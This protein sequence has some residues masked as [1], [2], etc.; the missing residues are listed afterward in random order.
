M[1]G[2]TRNVG[3]KVV[4]DGEKEYKQALSE[5]SAG[6]KTLA[7]EMRKLQAEYKGNTES[8]EYLT[9]AGELLERKLLQQ[10]DKVAKLREA[11]S[12]AAKEYGE[13]SER[14]QYYIQQLNNAEAAEFD[15]QHAIEEN[16]AALNGENQEMVGLG[17]TVDQLAG[18]LGINLPQGAKEALNGMKGLSAGTVAAMAAAA[19]AIAA[20][21]KV[22]SE[23]GKLTIEVAAQVD[24]YLSESAITGVPVEILQAWDYAAP[25]IDTDAETIKGAMTKI[26]QAMGDAA[27]G[28][29]SAQEKFA[30]LGVAITNEADGSLRSAEEVFYDVIDALGQMQAGTERDALAMELLGKSAQELNP[31]INEGSAALRKYA[32]EAEAAGY[33]L[34][35]QQTRK[36]GEVD[37]AYQKLQLQIE[38]NRKQLA[39]DFAPAAKAAMELFTDVVRKA[40]EMLER[41]GIIRNLASIIENLIDIL[42]T[43]GD[44]LKG[45]PGFK[46]GLSMISAVL[47]GIA[48]FCALIADTADV[49]A[50]LLTLDFS[51]VGNAM[52]FGKSSGTL[53]HWQTVY[54]QQEGTYDQY[55]EYYANKRGDSFLTDYGYDPETRQYYDKNTGNYIIYGTTAGGSDNWRGGLTWVGEA[56]PELV[57]LPQGSR[58]YSNQESMGRAGG[59][60]NYNIN[61]NGINELDE[62]LNWYNSRQVRERMA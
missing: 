58:I 54:M 53:S 50:G 48:Q 55:Q 37:D 19:T 25:L 38:A 47:G 17:D 8:T 2:P 29:E 18:K 4:L 16:T 31:L 36:L 1:P 24:E 61:V 27:G 5:L 40:G 52:G 33:I 22:V 28:S 44:I 12:F 46:Q 13:A 34:D 57:A 30:A 23:L 39:A 20:V 51:R 35:E 6:N 43:A 7:S 3:A 32:E 10:Q 62:V 15:L 14:T 11:V 26:T 21:V 9:K 60:I 56:G 45:I 49:I 42:R 59:V 41:S